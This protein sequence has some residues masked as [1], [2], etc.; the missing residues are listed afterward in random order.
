MESEN[1]R[2]LKDVSHTPPNGEPVPVWER[3]GER[4]D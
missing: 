4:D 1:P 2:T 3:G